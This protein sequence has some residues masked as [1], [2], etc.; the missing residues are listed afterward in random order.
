M[1]PALTGLDAAVR[2]ESA[3]QVPGGHCLQYVDDGT[4]MSTRLDTMASVQ[5][6]DAAAGAPTAR[7]SFSVAASSATTRRIYRKGREAVAAGRGA[8]GPIA[9]V[10]PT[11]V[12]GSPLNSCYRHGHIPLTPLPAAASDNPLLMVEYQP[13]RPCD[14]TAFV[15]ALAPYKRA[16]VYVGVEFDDLAHSADTLL[17]Q[18]LEQI[19]VVT[20]MQR[21]AGLGEAV[22]VAQSA[23]APRASAGRAAGA[24]IA[25]GGAWSR[26]RRPV[27]DRAQQ[28]HPRRSQPDRR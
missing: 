24:G 3:A 7:T 9:R 20:R 10:P 18:Q 15:D 28:R 14:R 1:R 2:P 21:F 17:L 26:P 11:F 16:L 5:F 27:A 4:E 22:V 12:K 19:G 13:D 23:R 8:W 25:R 6:P